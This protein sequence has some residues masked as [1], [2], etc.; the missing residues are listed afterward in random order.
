MAIG[1]AGR[2]TSLT[3][4]SFPLPLFPLSSPF[5]E[6][7]TLARRARFLT[8]PLFFSLFSMAAMSGARG[9]PPFALIPSPLVSPF[10]PP[11]FFFFFSSITRVARRPGVCRLSVVFLFPSPSFSL[12][13]F[14]FH[15]EGSR[16]R[17]GSTTAFFDPCL[18]FFF[19]L[20]FFLFFF[21]FF[22]RPVQ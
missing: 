17:P 10:P 1:G 18:S 15:G 14:L 6:V 7:K 21:L 5:H 8:S 20:L 16:N 9:G 11:L 13:F 4:F 3:L 2:W 12:F 19:P 22:L